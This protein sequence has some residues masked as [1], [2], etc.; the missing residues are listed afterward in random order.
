MIVIVESSAKRMKWKNELPL[1]LLLLHFLDFR[2]L[3]FIFK[4]GT[5]GGFLSTNE[6]KVEVKSRTSQL[7][8][9]K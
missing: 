3:T 7:D 8:G 2:D 9:W 4:A 5:V 1:K 6:N